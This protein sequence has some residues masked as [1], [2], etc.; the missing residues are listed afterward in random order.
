MGLIVLRPKMKV[1]SLILLVAV[2]SSQAADRPQ[3]TCQECTH[4]M[5]NLGWYVKTYAEYITAYLV[6]DFCPTTG[7]D[8]CAHHIEEHYVEMIY[9]II[10]HFVIDGANHICQM[11]GIWQMWF[12]P[13]ITKWSMMA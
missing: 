10:D 12:A 7:T 13:S 2:S 4:E 5:H 3:F 11:M 6:E 9:A 1:L 8:D